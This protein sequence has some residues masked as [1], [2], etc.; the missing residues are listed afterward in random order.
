MR[1][2]LSLL[3]G[4]LM[5]GQAAASSQADWQCPDYLNSELPTLEAGSLPLCKTLQQARAV[6]IVNTA[7]LCGYTSQFD[8]L[9]ALYQRYR[10]QGLLILGIPTGDFGGQEYE[11]S[12]RTAKVCHANYGV[13]FP[14][15]RRGCVRCEEPQPLLKLAVSQSGVAPK[16]NFYKYLFNP[17]SGEATAFPSKT[18]P[19]DPELIDAIATTLTP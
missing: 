7:S 5:A 14:V 11:D 12:E 19:T 17:R 16:W 4:L 6:L 8:G 2:A 18:K 13:T 9:E 15:F 1:I 3:L 10:D